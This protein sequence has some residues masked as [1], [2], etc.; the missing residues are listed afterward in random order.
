MISVGVAQILNTVS[1]ERNL[2]T[3]RKFLRRF[4]FEKADLVLFPECGLSGFS[5]RAGECSRDRLA[6]V[7]GELEGWSRETGISVVLPSIL[8]EEREVFNAG[9]WISPSG[10]ETFFKVGLTA[11]ERTFFSAP[12]RSPKVFAVGDFRFGLLICCE[13]QEPASTYFREG[14]V[15]AILWPGYWGWTVEDGWDAMD[16]NGRPNRI[17]ANM[18]V[19]KRPL[20]QSN[21]AGND[22]EGG[23]GGPQGLSLV[24]DADNRVAH[25]ARHSVESGFLVIL[26]KGPG[27]TRVAGC[28]EI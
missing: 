14:D 10:T 6:A 17:F 5:T 19:W 11:A 20:I 27:G 22:V 13:A 4:A 15:D 9:F 1:L 25:R 3:A 24:I 7:L 26:E 16:L 21:F 12:S 18:D 2:E 8:R 28:R 23:Q